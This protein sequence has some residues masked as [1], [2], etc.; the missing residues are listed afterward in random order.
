LAL[1]VSKALN[2]RRGRAVRDTIAYVRHPQRSFDQPPDEPTVR[3]GSIVVAFHPQLLDIDTGLGA[4]MATDAQ[5]ALSGAVTRLG[6][7]TLFDLPLSGPMS[8]FVPMQQG[9]TIW[10][11]GL[12]A[13]GKT[14]LARGVQCALVES[15]RPAYVLDGDIL[16]DGLCR[17]LGFEPEE[18]RENVRRVSEVAALF[19]DAGLV[20]IAALISPE[21]SGRASARALHT[22]LGLPFLEVFVDTPVE[23]CERRDP[24]GQYAL[25]RRGR[26]KGFTGV[27]APYERPAAADVVVR[28]DIES[29]ADGV[30][31]V[32]AALRRLTTGDDVAS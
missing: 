17:D 25:A 29:V 7:R 19:A 15:S 24:K 22:R 14:T 11:T 28:A 13:A 4:V 9:A 23:V 12:P 10:L 32:L 27:D 31:A 21:A 6:G 5:G 8:P 3:N 18:R 26:L 1:T 30:T 2:S 20:A 16:R